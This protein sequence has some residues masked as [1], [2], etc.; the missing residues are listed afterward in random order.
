[1]IRHEVADVLRRAAAT[2]QCER[3]AAITGLG[4]LVGRWPP[5]TAE[6][7]AVAAALVRAISDPDPKVRVRAIRGLGRLPTPLGFLAVARA[8]TDDD[9]ATRE[10]AVRTLVLLDPD[11]AVPE[12]VAVLHDERAP[13]RCSALVGLRAVPNIDSGMLAAL[14]AGLPDQDPSVQGAAMA[15]LRALATRSPQLREAVT[16]LADRGLHADSPQSREIS[17]ELLRQL[18]V[19]GHRQRC[20]LALSDPDPRVRQRAERGLRNG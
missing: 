1:M 17:I 2:A 13:V 3:R 16:A 5:G 15:S 9:Y 20:L 4:T 18:G 7:E 11:R 12:I 10:A 8:M 19:P 14:A 6:H